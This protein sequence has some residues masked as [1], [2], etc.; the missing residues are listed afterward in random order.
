MT[1]LTQGALGR[2][3]TKWNP[4]DPICEQFFGCEK[5]VSFLAAKSKVAGLR[6]KLEMTYHAN[7]ATQVYNP[8]EAVYFVKYDVPY[9]GF[10]NCNHEL[11]DWLEALGAE[12]S[13]KIFY[14]PDFIGGMVSAAVPLP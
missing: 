7:L 4:R 3:Q 8:R 13:G 6:V 10:H 1:F 11:A 14:N 2:K 12:V 9:W 5:V